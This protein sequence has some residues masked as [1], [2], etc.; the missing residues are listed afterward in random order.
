MLSLKD[1]QRA[2]LVDKLP[3]LANVTAGA[4]VFGQAMSDRRFS[5]EIAGLGIAL[6]FVF[7]G[8]SLLFAR[9]RSR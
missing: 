1:E 4:M 2:V 8:V 3:D 6:W 5:F 9:R 7:I